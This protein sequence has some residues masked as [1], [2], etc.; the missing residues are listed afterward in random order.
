MLRPIEHEYA[1]YIAYTRELEKYCNELE[2]INGIQTRSIETLIQETEKLKE[3][4]QVQI[5][6]KKSRSN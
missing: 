6:L 5:L 4:L 2:N 3:A 1:S